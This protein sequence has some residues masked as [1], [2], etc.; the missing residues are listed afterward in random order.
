MKKLVELRIRSADR[1]GFRMELGVAT[2]RAQLGD[3]NRRRDL[4]RRV[5]SR[6][7]LEVLDAVKGGR[8]TAEQ[9][10]RLVDEWGWEGYRRHLDIAPPA[11]AFVVPTLDAHVAR[12]LETIEKDGTRGVYRK[13]LTH[14][15]DYVVEIEEKKVRLGDRPWHTVARHL[16]GDVK[17]SLRKSHA[18]NTIRTIMGSWSGFFEWAI[19][20]EQSEA[21]AAGRPPLLEVNPV[22]AAKVWGSIELTRHRFLSPTEFWKLLEVSPEPMRAQYATLCLGGLRV[23]ELCAL[24]PA[25]VHLPTHLHVGPWGGW[26]PK[27]Y[28]RSKHGVRDVPLHA[29][30]VPLLEHYAATY[31]GE[32]TFFVNPGT[33]FGWNE[34]AFSRRFRKDIAAAGM[35]SGAWSRKESGLTRKADGVTPHTLRHTLASWMAQQDIQLMKIALILGDTEETVRQ[36]YAHL[37]PSDLDRSINRVGV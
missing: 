23:G 3:L 12:W 35:T 18:A 27:G 30:L 31:A 22:R 10:E 19:E 34:S 33:G 14:L 1:P 29:R 9:I 26:V 37:L 6:G 28:P 24:P 21:G 4:L 32:D 5:H 7:E 20:R 2:T 15:R 13:G 11:P 16:I 25:H 17:G 8:A 36:H